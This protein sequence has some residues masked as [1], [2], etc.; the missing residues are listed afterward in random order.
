MKYLQKVKEQLPQTY[1]Y[2]NLILNKQF[3]WLLVLINAL[4]TLYTWVYFSSYETEI[5][6]RNCFFEYEANYENI[7]RRNL[8]LAKHPECPVDWISVDDNATVIFNDDFMIDKCSFA[9][10][11][12]VDDFN[13]KLTNF[14]EIQ[15]GAQLPKDKEYF[16][17]KCSSNQDEFYTTFAKIF[18]KEENSD[19]EKINVFIYLMDSIYRQDWVENLPK[20]SEF[21]IKTLGVKT[22]NQYNIVGDGTISNVVPLL[23]SKH[24]HELPPVNKENKK[25]SYVDHVYPFI[26]NEFKNELG[27][28]TLYAEDMSFIG[29]FQMRF[30][31]MSK[32]PTDHYMRPYQLSTLKIN[33]KPF[34]IGGRTHARANIE[35][36]EDF[37][38]RYRNT[39]F[40]GTL[41]ISEYSHNDLNTI[42]YIDE[43]LLKFLEFFHRDIKLREKTIL[44][45]MSDHGPRFQETRRSTVGSLKERNP[46]LS[47]HIPEIFK[48][49]YPLEFKN[50]EENSKRILSPFDV[51]RTLIDIISLE[52]TG[53]LS[54]RNDGRAKSL[55][56]SISKNRT[57]NEAGIDSFWCSCKKQE[58]A[59]VNEKIIKIAKEFVNFINDFLLID[60]KDKCT[61]LELNNV[62]NAYLVNK[63][64]EYLE[65]IFQ[66]ETKNNDG[67]L[68]EFTAKERFNSDG[69]STYIFDK[70]LISRINKYKNAAH[71][72]AND[73]PNL[74]QYCFCKN[75]TLTSSI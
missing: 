73:Y 19:N 41:F 38:K 27:Y 12:W 37:I 58:T 15:N 34:C 20:S 10:V 28:K 29:T 23:T 14:Q 63:K 40:F 47:I 45:V 50:L 30:V 67:G 51:H 57:C 17:I 60:I 66:I 69:S 5:I 70:K 3:I 53:K 2:L 6:H 33:N 22:F 68:Y 1:P 13:Y 52:K 55:F 32:P 36:G 75:Q 25:S 26:W 72:I 24:E 61:R 46:F 48:K 11:E 56:S 35:Y 62:N 65:Y 42:K 43:D 64:Q 54:E 39:G 16:H 71:C 4:L 74:R 59:V 44:F 7:F 18:K 9:T 31:G 49:K 8:T 21:L